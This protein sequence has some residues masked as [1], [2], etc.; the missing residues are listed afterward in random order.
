MAVWLGIILKVNLGCEKMRRAAKAN[1]G[2][3]GLP[4]RD[5]N[6]MIK[7]ISNSLSMNGFIIFTFWKNHIQRKIFLEGGRL[8]PPLKGTRLSILVC[9]EK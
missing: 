5:C 8:R 3:R 2:N 4:W 6:K 9:I 7:G 1:S